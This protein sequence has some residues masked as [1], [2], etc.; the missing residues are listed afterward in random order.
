VIDLIDF[1]FFNKSTP[2]YWKN[3]RFKVHQYFSLPKCDFPGFHSI[4]IASDVIIEKFSYVGDAIA[5]NPQHI[6]NLF[7]LC[8]FPVVNVLL[9][10]IGYNSL[11]IILD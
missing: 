4:F 7:Y 8:L 2:E 5:F 1:K 3:I 9:D 11:R 6:S 10:W